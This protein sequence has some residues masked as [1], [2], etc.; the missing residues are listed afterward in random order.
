MNSAWHTLRAVSVN[1]KEFFFFHVGFIELVHCVALE[2][3]ASKFLS[4]LLHTKRK[5]LCKCQSSSSISFVVEKKWRGLFSFSW[6]PK[7]AENDRWSVTLWTIFNIS[8][9]ML[10]H[11]IWTGLGAK[12][13]KVF[14]I[15][16][17]NRHRELSSEHRKQT[18]DLFISH[19][20][21]SR[22]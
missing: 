16:C 9:P 21:M 11:P 4:S 22:A 20:M 2:E 14:V 5:H 8:K 6:L 7:R 18:F 17:S 3:N 13:H 19:G 10:R 15:S 12:Q 1:S